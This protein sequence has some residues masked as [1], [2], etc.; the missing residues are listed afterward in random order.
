M[1]PPALTCL[2]RQHPKGS[3]LEN[4]PCT[5]GELSAPFVASPRYPAP[6]L[7]LFSQGSGLLRYWDGGDGEGTVCTQN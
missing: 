5:S 3:D 2:S 6:S 4:Q 7:L 1:L